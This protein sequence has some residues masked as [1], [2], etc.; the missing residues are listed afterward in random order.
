MRDWAKEWDELKANTEGATVHLALVVAIDWVAFEA[1]C[2]NPRHPGRWAFCGLNLLA[3]MVLALHLW[4]L[5]ARRSGV[6]TTLDR[7]LGRQ[8]PPAKPPSTRLR[9]VIEHD[10]H[11]YLLIDHK[12]Q[13]AE[14]RGERTAAKLEARRRLAEQEPQRLPP[15]PKREVDLAFI[16]YEAFEASSSP[17]EALRLEAAILAGAQA[18]HALVE[19]LEAP[20]DDVP[21]S[22]V[23]LPQLTPGAP[24]G[25]VGKKRGR[26]PGR[27]T[28]EGPRS[29]YAPK[30]DNTGMVS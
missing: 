8:A 23:D 14:A 17:Q 2:S 5:T 20:P 24:E 1:A 19:A 7:W 27:K 3:A 29:K 25:P 6:T 28:G 22:V 12:V 4:K 26:P 18:S 16:P 9:P 11:A 21:E 13:D 30:G 10:G 15:R